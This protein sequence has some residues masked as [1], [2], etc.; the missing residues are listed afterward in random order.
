MLFR[1]ALF[2]LLVVVA[3]CDAPQ[4][5]Q[6]SAPR[7]AQE[8]PAARPLSKQQVDDRSERCA[9]MSREQF[10]RAWKDAKESSA[11]GQVKAEFAYHYN[12]KSGTCFYLLTVALPGTLK[13]MLFDVKDG[14][15]YG[16]YLGPAQVDS[17]AA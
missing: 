12:T 2:T 14:E 5:A 17:P 11:D 8:T 6:E 13:K 16:E 10:Q 7:N 15:L 4:R 9:G 1:L 3:A